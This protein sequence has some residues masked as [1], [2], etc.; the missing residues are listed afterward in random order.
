MPYGVLLKWRHQFVPEC[1]GTIC[2]GIVFVFLSVFFDQLDGLGCQ[3][4]NVVPSTPS[5]NV[6][7]GDFS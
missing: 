5:R 1:G 6:L 4:W 3:A 7:S 2:E